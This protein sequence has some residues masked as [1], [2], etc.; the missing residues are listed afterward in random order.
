MKS[1]IKLLTEA[2]S[3]R[4]QLFT[5]NPFASDLA[6]PS[7][8]PPLPPPNIRPR[9]LPPDRPPPPAQTA[10]LSSVPMASNM[11]LAEVKLQELET[12][13]NLQEELEGAEEELKEAAEEVKRKEKE[14][15]LAKRRKAKAN[16]DVTKVKNADGYRDK[17]IL[18][19][20]SRM[21]HFFL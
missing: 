14:L 13:L 1:I 8:P 18:L 21:K 11:T 5:G 6:V 7:V 2:L 3:K 16:N 20:Y 9:N 19:F 4:N 15:F 12:A 10:G 17:V